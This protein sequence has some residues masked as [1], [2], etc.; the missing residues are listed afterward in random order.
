MPDTCILTGEAG[1]NPDDCTTHEHET[2]G[3]EA[4]QTW[5]IEIRFDFTGTK[6]EADEIAG[7]AA[8]GVPGDN[9]EVTA[10]FDENWNEVD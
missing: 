5:R 3:A 6:A 8:N 1:E 4:G 10:I 7:R 2:A 9:G